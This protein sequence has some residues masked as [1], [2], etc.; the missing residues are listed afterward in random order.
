MLGFTGMN[1][2]QRMDLRK[3]KED[4]VKYTT[5]FEGMPIIVQKPYL[6]EP[7]KNKSSKFFKVDKRPLSLD[8][9]KKKT[10]RSLWCNEYQTGSQN[11]F[12]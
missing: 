10:K 6:M 8:L 2:T 5:D 3:I 4:K 7:K 1:A 12:E 11:L 9:A